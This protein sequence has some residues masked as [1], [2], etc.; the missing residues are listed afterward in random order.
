LQL[1]YNRKIATVV[2]QRSLQEEFGL[3]VVEGWID[4]ISLLLPSEQSVKA[5][6]TSCV[7]PS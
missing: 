5:R 7:L 6:G 1:D 4:L 2:L 3:P